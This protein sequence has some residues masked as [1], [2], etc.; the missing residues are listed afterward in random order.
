VQTELFDYQ[1]DPDETRDHSASNPEKVREL[2]A[3][4]EQ[5]PEFGQ[6]A[7]KR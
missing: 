1:S 7:S 5:V 4:L 3:L 6:S 2:L